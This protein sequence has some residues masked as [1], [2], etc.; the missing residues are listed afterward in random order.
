MQGRGQGSRRG[1]RVFVCDVPLPRLPRDS[2]G[3]DLDSC[4]VA[5]GTRQS[6]E[7][8]SQSSHLMPLIVVVHLHCY[9]HVQLIDFS[10]DRLR[11]SKNLIHS[12]V[13]LNHPE[14]A[15]RR[16][17]RDL[18]DHTSYS[19][20]RHHPSAPCQDKSA[21][22]QL[23]RSGHS[24]VRGLI[25]AESALSCRHSSVTIHCSSCMLQCGSFRSILLRCMPLCAAQAQ[26]CLPLNSSIQLQ[27]KPA[28]H[29]SYTRKNVGFPCSGVRCEAWL[30]LPKRTD[31][32][33]PP[34]VLVA[35][36]GCFARLCFACFASALTCMMRICLVD[37]VVA[38]RMGACSG[39][40][41]HRSVRGL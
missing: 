8:S 7:D 15:S 36:G 34:V 28:R 16:A 21:H 33:K 9:I 10:K 39:R 18:G 38:W 12:P 27:F 37:A 23:N 26:Y 24:S 11:N 29:R 30:Y 35:H 6:A 41:G 20:A 5:P 2:L 25:V 22:T 13:Q 31:G 17:D 14:D 1:R 32:V 3:L 40:K 4:I 19:R